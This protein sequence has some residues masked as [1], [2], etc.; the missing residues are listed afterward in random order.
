MVKCLSDYWQETNRGKLRTFT[1]Q[2]HLMDVAY[3]WHSTIFL[4]CVYAC[5]WRIKGYSSTVQY[6]TVSGWCWR[7]CSLHLNPHLKHSMCDICWRCSQANSETR[8]Q[9]RLRR[10]ALYLIRRG[11]KSIT[12]DFSGG[13]EC[14]TATRTL[15]HTY[16][17]F[18]DASCIS[19]TVLL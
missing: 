15:Q 10:S 4:A 7:K 17:P 3:K 14:S 6:V 13:G 2:A 11:S 8:F 19:Q 9:C 12:P 16:K 18:H 1:R 5:R